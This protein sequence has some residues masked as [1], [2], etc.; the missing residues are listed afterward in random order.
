M[1]LN[2]PFIFGLDF[3]KTGHH[4]QYLPG[5]TMVVSNM[6]PRGSRIEGI[7]KV[8]WFGIDA[9]VKDLHRSFANLTSADVHYWE[10]IIRDSL[11]DPSYCADHLRQLL[12]LDELPLEFRSLPE[13]TVVPMRVP[14]MTIRN[15]HP[16]F[17]WLP[18]FLETQISNE[19][20]QPSTA[21]T[22]ARAYRE[23]FDRYSEETD[24]PPEFCDWQGHD[25]SARGMCGTEASAK[26][27][28]GHLT[29][30][31]GTDTVASI[32]AVKSYYRGSD[33]IGG[34]VPATEHSIQCAAGPSGERE[35]LE[36][37]L[38]T[39]QNGILSV[40]SDSYDFWG[41]VKMLGTDYKNAIMARAGKFVVRP[42]SGDPV[43]ILVGDPT[44]TDEMVRKG[45]I[46]VLWDFFGGSVSSKGYRILD[47]H[48]G[49]I[50]GDSITLERQK[51]ILEG[52]KQ[53]KFASCNV[54]L[55]IGSY[56]YQH[57]TRDTFGWAIK[58][59]YMERNG[60]SFHTFKQ[61]KTDNGTKFSAK[62]LPFVY[63]GEDGQLKM[64]DGVSMDDFLSEDNELC[65]VDSRYRD[66]SNI[67]L[68]LASQPSI[69][70]S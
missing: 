58:A 70:S 36:H 69:F 21:A 10:G 67:R 44:A 60:Q 62:G 64:K 29:S 41:F 16:D 12:S 63:Y 25:F 49:A 52:L 47:S 34:S 4:K 23:V 50:Y 38:K 3:Y 54:V 32:Y 11:N 46:E 35:V 28:M 13:G 55:G 24:S 56:T 68:R 1:N 61:P 48:I 6:T 2:I 30:F 53:K 45:L 19:I 9:Y 37:L 18:N 43:K 40:V 7:D 15:T 17:A 14:C 27:G 31:F 22:I 8:V 57:V 66:F 26:S 42:D 5:T 51:Q 33:F 39:Y 65:I 20:W 59:T